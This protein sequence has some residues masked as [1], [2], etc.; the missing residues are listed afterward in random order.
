MVVTGNIWFN[1]NIW[2]I[3]FIS[4]YKSHWIICCRTSKTMDKKTVSY[5]PENTV[6]L[7]F[8]NLNNLTIYCSI[9]KKRFQRNQVPSIK[10]Y[11]TSWH[12]A[13]IVSC[14]HKLL[15]H[16]VIYF[17]YAPLCF[18]SQRF[19]FFS[20]GKNRCYIFYI[21]CINT[22]LRKYADTTEGGVCT[23]VFHGLLT[24]LAVAP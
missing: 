12:P 5:S 1:N 6:C 8:S 7:I 24:F 11:E 13:M 20:E 10:S 4:I 23:V 21:S 16:C 3:P 14:F 9:T 19:A 22:L 17:H 2:F 15:R 18:G